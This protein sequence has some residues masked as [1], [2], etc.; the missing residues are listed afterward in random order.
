MANIDILSL[1]IMVMLDILLEKSKSNSE[2][3]IIRAF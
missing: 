3:D 2:N 1:D